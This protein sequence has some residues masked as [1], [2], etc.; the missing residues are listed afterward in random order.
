MNTKAINYV[1]SVIKPKY[2][3]HVDE[4]MITER[5]L[6]SN[7]EYKMLEC[8]SSMIRQVAEAQ[9]SNEIYE[10]EQLSSKKFNREQW[11]D[12]LKNGKLSPMFLTVENNVTKMFKEYDYSTFINNWKIVGD[13]GFMPYCES[14]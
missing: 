5:V 4:S 2:L 10:S 12:E 8:D 11:L 14:I 6:R 7:I 9:L 3:K 13:N 1:K